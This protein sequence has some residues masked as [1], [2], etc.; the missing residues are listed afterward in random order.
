MTDEPDLKILAPR[1]S[2]PNIT[3]RAFM[4]GMGVT[5]AVGGGVILS[6]C[7]A[8]GSSSPS[9][10]PGAASSGPIE[11]Q[12]NFY[13]WAAYD[14]PSLF[15]KFTSET[16][17]KTQVDVFDSNEQAIAKLNTAQGTSGFDIVV[18]TGVYIPLMVQQQ[19]IQ[20]MDTSRLKN[21]SNIDSQYL[22]QKWDPGNKYSV[23]KDWGTTGYMYDKTVITRKMETWQDFIDAMQ[24][25]AKNN[26]SVLASP[27]NLTSLYFWTQNP[28]VD[29]TTTDPAQLKKCEQF[30]LSQVAPYVKAYDSY[31]A[32]TM[33]QGKY[34]LSMV[35]SGDARAGMIRGKN[36]QNIV[37]T[38]PKPV[39]ELWMDNWVLV[40]N[41]PH[42]NAA[43][44]WIDFILEPKNSLVDLQ[45]H[46]YATGIKGVPELAKA[47]GLPLLDI[48]FPSPEVV[49]TLV[50]GAVNSALDT[51]NNI[52]QQAQAVSAGG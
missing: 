27:G 37:Y 14:A 1:S 52:F 30:I 41:A 15:K 20:P 13:N 16:G 22:N 26:T 5:A 24:N 39:S 2:L 25:E 31:P 42:P 18:P 48:I 7:G 28:V 33:T 17:A 51:L 40:A 38:Q 34:A 44:A 23:P 35:W 49:A 36:T 19:L 32:I 46:G 12:L 6:A 50:P 21:F 43:Y 9:Q 3:R 8:G 45:Y 47:A 10:S 4:A 11:N 29:W